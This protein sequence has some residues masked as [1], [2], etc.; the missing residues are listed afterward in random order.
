MRMLVCSCTCDEAGL[1]R[2]VQNV[3]QGGLNLK[4]RVIDV[5]E[6][7]H[8]R[9]VLRHCQR[10]QPAAGAHHSMLELWV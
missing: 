3:L 9:S 10:L 5:K 6:A 2:S 7:S 8:K 4:N 1:S